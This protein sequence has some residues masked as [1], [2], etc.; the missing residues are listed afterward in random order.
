MEYGNTGGAE[1]NWNY[2]MGGNGGGGGQSMPIYPQMGQM[3]TAGYGGGQQWLHSNQSHAQNYQSSMPQPQGQASPSPFDDYNQ[4][5]MRYTNLPKMEGASM[6]RQQGGQSMGMSAMGNNYGGYP[7]SMSRNG[8]G[9]PGA[10]MGQGANSGYGGNCYETISLCSKYIWDHTSLPL[11]TAL[12]CFSWF[13]K[14]AS[15]PVTPRRINAKHVHGNYIG[16]ICGGIERL[17]LLFDNRLIDMSGGYSEIR[18][19]AAWVKGQR[20]GVGVYSQIMVVSAW[21]IIKKYFE[22]FVTVHIHIRIGFD[23]RHFPSLFRVIRI[24][25]ATFIDA[26]IADKVT[27]SQAAA[28]SQRSAPKTPSKFWPQSKP[29]GTPTPSAPSPP[30]AQSHTL[31]PSS[32]ASCAR[33]QPPGE[34]PQRKGCGCTFARPLDV[35]IEDFN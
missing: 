4:S 32:P 8:L 33:T 6:G 10:G 22:S 18:S 7:G 28:K 19:N 26:R 14:R 11:S 23:T 24:V 34:L 16:Q 13:R 1:F 20:N 30:P 3:D 29:H 17:T 21:K 12:C 25:F 9:N 31:H 27:R 5:M 15:H 35:A 2:S